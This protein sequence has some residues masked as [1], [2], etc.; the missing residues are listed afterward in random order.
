LLCAVASGATA[1]ASSSPRL[2]ARKAD[3]FARFM[4]RSEQYRRVLLVLTSMNT[5]RQPGAW[6]TPNRPMP[7]SVSRTARPMTAPAAYLS[8]TDPLSV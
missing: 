8:A 2:R 4:Q 1:S 3:T 6:Q 7:R 5:P